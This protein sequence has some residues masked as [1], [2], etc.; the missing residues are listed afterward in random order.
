MTFL[1]TSKAAKLL[2]VSRDTV[3]RMCKD[4]R[5]RAIQPIK[6]YRIPESEI[7]RM[8]AAVADADEVA[9]DAR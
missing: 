4:K 6:E 2:G 5:L 3:L 8:L 9:S 1:T 7:E